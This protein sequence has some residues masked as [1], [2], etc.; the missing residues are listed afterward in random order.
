M[1][2]HTGNIEATVKAIE[3]VDE[4]IGKIFE[5]CK[6][7]NAQQTIIATDDVRIKEVADIFNANTQLT[8]VEH[9][10][11]T[12]RIFEVARNLELDDD[13]IIVNVQADEPFI[14]KKS[15]VTADCTST[16]NKRVDAEPPVPHR[17]KHS[18]LYTV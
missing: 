18:T 7:S 8:S 3:A 14:D 10:S 17:L 5:Q 15:L 2:G 12:D 13:H 4:C 9:L 6:K 1:V 11:G 16:F